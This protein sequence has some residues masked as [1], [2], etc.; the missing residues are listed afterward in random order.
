MI[1]F[2]MVLVLSFICSLSA[3]VHAEEPDSNYSNS[4]GERAS[5]PEKG[6]FWQY[7]YQMQEEQKRIKEELSKRG[8][9]AEADEDEKDPCQNKD[10]WSSDCGFVDP[11][12]DYEWSQIQKDALLRAAVMDPNDATKVH[13]L[14]KFNAWA[15]NKAVTM[16]KMWQWNMI[17]DQDLNPNI[18][19]P[20]ATFALQAMS[21]MRS[22]QRIDITRQIS[23][24]GGFLLFFS[25]K[26]CEACGIQSPAIR[27]LGRWLDIPVYEGSLSGGCHE[28]FEGGFCQ[29]GERIKEAARYLNVALVPDVWLYLKEQDMW[30]RVSSGM[31]SQSTIASRIELF[32]QGVIEAIAKG[33]SA[34]EGQTAPVDFDF[35]R[36]KLSRGAISTIEDVVE[37]GR[38]ED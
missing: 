18:T 5:T 20:I 34:A 35:S 30:L 28:G 25:R 12:L 2:L 21:D 37:G 23:E 14:Q 26:E 32:F 22:K 10:T 29:E 13:S 27:G 38:N 36:E 24:Q 3:V 16:M 1:R 17:Q 19:A 6:W 8:E 15:V 11:G 4:R 33:M 9:L 7:W 31:E